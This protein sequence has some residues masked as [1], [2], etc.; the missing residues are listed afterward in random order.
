MAITGTFA[1]DFSDFRNEVIAAKVTLTSFESDSEKVAA[2]LNRMSNSF[3]GV[4]I[5]EQATLMTAAIEHAG[6]ISALTAAELE[7]AGKKAEEA[8]EKMR[9]MG[10][11]VPP[12]LTKITEAA[13]AQVG[14]IGQIEQ[15]LGPL[16]PAFVAAFNVA[17]VTL[18][19][20]ALVNLAKETINYAGHLDDLSKESGL[21]TD[22]LQA[23]GAKGREVGV[24]MEAIS[25][26]AVQL[27]RRVAAGD[28]S[29]AGAFGRLGIKMSELKGLSVDDLVFKTAG[30]LGNLTDATHQSELG[31]DLFGKTSKAVIAI[32]RD[33]K[34]GL[35]GLIEQQKAL[36]QVIS[37]DTI[38]RLDE[39]GDA[40]TRFGNAVKTA[41]AGT[42]AVG[43]SVWDKFVA[44]LKESAKYTA[45][46]SEAIDE[47][48]GV[49]RQAAKDVELHAA[50]IAKTVTPVDELA[51]ELKRLRDDAMAP[52][53]ETQ[54]ASI[55]ELQSYGVAQDKIAKLVDT[56][57]IAVKR[58]LDTHREAEAAEKKFADAMAEV[59]SAGRDYH[60]TL[61]RLGLVVVESVQN[62]LA[63]GVAQDKVA[64]AYRL[65]AAEVKAVALALADEKKAADEAQKSAEATATTLSKLWSEYDALRVQSG[66]TATEQ[67]IAQIVKEF[68]VTAANMAKAGTLTVET[69]TALGLV[70]QEKLRAI[71]ANWNDLAAHSKQALEDTAVYAENT[72]KAALERIG[73][74]TP[75]YL[76]K[77]RTAAEAARNAADGIGEAI[78]IAV[79]KA[80]DELDKLDARQDKSKQKAL[81][82][83]VAL[84][85]GAGAN[86]DPVVA[87]YLSAGYTLGEAAS[88]AAG[89]G[90]HI[91][92]PHFAGGVENF[93]GGL[94]IVHK[95]EALV[96]LPAGTDVIPGGR[97]LG[98][99]NVT[100]YNSF[101]IVDTESNI[102]RRVADHLTRSVL[103][104]RKIAS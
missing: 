9:K 20:E 29:T 36:G 24:D 87:G 95:D 91:G 72:Y 69:Y 26:A 42:L 41:T 85:G 78:T 38:K 84:P 79:G 68:D 10:V 33:N 58:Y 39:A 4:R 83:S 43:F 104:G 57:S 71:S 88:L 99:G 25:N 40:M 1:A 54:K 31:Y 5:A 35:A 16:G 6:G 81:G 66:G 19:A 18:S 46:E 94:A 28:D 48:N 12:G 77:L 34:D 80:V 2:S 75:A 53:S 11:D 52:L 37:G 45:I 13:Q 14:V 30:A 82:G 101:Q 76:E 67:R 47:A 27:A 65:T 86:V 51:N 62:T 32:V 97:G 102:A 8:A 60:E 74:F 96:N 15:A 70:A 73:D 3:T 93:A 49:H 17:A 64:T 55:L 56:T 103:A 100:V 98:G 89:K 7:K 63:A 92:V 22:A 90:A 44:V 61:D 21:S 50:A 23:L 59:N